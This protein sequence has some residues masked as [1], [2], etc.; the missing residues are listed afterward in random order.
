[1]KRKKWFL[2]LC[3]VLAAFGMLVPNGVGTL[4]MAQDVVVIANPGVGDAQLAAAALQDMFLGDRSRWSDNSRVVISSLR[5]GNV[6]EQFLRA[7]MKRTSSQFSTYWKRQVFTGK[8]KMPPAFATD[9]EM[10][11]FVAKTDGAIGYVGAGAPLD[12]VKV[13]SISP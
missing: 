3:G 13:V 11:D 5:E 1:M 8:G 12:S 7:F 2:A 9:A 6:H 4:A 10:V